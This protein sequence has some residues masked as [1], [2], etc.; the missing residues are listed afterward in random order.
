MN[1]ILTG[2]LLALGSSLSLADVSEKREAFAQS[3]DQVLVEEAPNERPVNWRPLEEEYQRYFDEYNDE[4]RLTALEFN[5]LEQLL[6]VAADFVAIAQN[7]RALDHQRRIL[8]ELQVR[9]KA[10]RRHLVGMQ[11]SFIAVRNF[12]AAREL[13]ET[14]ADDQLQSVPAAN[15]HPGKPDY[16]TYWIQNDQHQYLEQVKFALGDGKRRLVAVYH[17]HCG[18]TRSALQALNS[19]DSSIIQDLLKDTTWLLPPD[20]KFPFL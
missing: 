15:S 13:A 20:G 10:T 16:H 2:I 6:A 19:D 8:D 9:D 1:Y 5:E 4:R 7:S 12:D 11:L 17:P 14:N 18:F 3:V